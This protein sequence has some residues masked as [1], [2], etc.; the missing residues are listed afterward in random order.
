MA[1]TPQRGPGMT[2]PATYQVPYRSTTGAYANATAGPIS[3]A[4]SE[5]FVVPAG[6]Y[7]VQPGSYTFIQT[8]DPITGLWRNLS[9]HPGVTRQIES[10]GQ[11]VRLANL[12]GCAVGAV[13]T[14]VGS[15]YTSAPTVT[16]SAGSSTWTA[17]VGGAINST[18]TVTTAGAGY[19]Y[20]PTLLFSAP[21]AG[22]VQ[23][24]AVA[25]V[26]AGAISSVTVVNQG[27][28]YTVAPTIT[29]IPDARDTI[30]TT[31]V[32]TVNSTLA[33]S[34]TITAVTCTSG[35][36]PQTSVPTLS[37]SGGGGASAA[38][39][40]VMCFACTGF[41]VAVNGAGYGNA[42]PMLILTGGGVTSA[43]P[44]AVVNP[45]LGTGLFVPRQ[46]NI[47]ATSCLLYTS[48]SPRDRTRSR[49]PSSA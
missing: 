46:A 26:S 4:A 38:A 3:L 20:P 12:S 28:G 37:F 24:S 29:V 39:T 34:G 11:N 14:N 7:M 48:P 2:T 45:Q 42:Q 19:T 1:N 18:V 44:G 30:T 8:K 21:P 15:G 5:T 17:I 43:T 47:S 31:A 41:S 36:T 25:V 32:L 6:L 10:D 49:M 33:G 22:G 16:A 27:A 13:I 9:G 40:V 23:A 35:G